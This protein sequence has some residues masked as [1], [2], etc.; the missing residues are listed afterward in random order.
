MWFWNKPFVANIAIAAA[1]DT[2]TDNQHDHELAKTIVG[3]TRYEYVTSALIQSN[4]RVLRRCRVLVILCA[5]DFKKR[6]PQA[7]G[8]DETPANSSNKFR[9]AAWNMTEFGETGRYSTSQ[10]GRAAP[11]AAHSRTLWVPVCRAIDQK[12][13]FIQFKPLYLGSPAHAKGSYC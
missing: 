13:T 12:Y 3:R 6:P 5:C 8:P 1:H 11:R 2:T 4:Y 7:K 9:K 10:E